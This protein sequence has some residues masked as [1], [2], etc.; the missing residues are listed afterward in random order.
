MHI[1][2]LMFLSGEYPSG[3]AYPF[4]LR[5]FNITERIALTTPATF[6]VGENG[7]GKSTLLRAIAHRCDIH[8]WEIPG[9]LRYVINPHEEEL[10]RYIRVS[11]SDGMV[12]FS[13]RKYFKTSLPFSMNG[14]LLRLERW[15]ISA[16][17]RL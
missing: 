17:A 12:P 14:L 10:Y 4:N 5:N 11:W 9:G 1:R 13:H 8:I 16:E 6:F 7:T 2:E 3:S 15:T